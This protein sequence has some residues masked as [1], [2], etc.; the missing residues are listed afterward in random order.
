[1]CAVYRPV[2]IC[3]FLSNFSFFLYFRGSSF[4]TWAFFWY[5]KISY[6]FHSCLTHW[7]FWMLVLLSFELNWRKVL[8]IFKLELRL[9]EILVYHFTV[10]IRAFSIIIDVVEQEISLAYSVEEAISW[11][12]RHLNLV[13]N[14]HLVVWDHR[15]AN[16][17]LARWTS[18]IDNLLLSL[19][20]K[21]L[22][23][24]LE[25]FILLCSDFRFIHPS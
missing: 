10:L 1:M 8:Q 23:S 25:Q 4:S 14:L 18:F 6:W 2:K 7:V 17:F 21:N 13:I 24:L 16:H 9:T 22:C 15:I 12:D 5:C 3:A 11:G 20:L 19:L